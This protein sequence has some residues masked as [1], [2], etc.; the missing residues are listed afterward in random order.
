MG[1]SDARWDSHFGEMVMDSNTVASL[2][3]GDVRWI[4][5][6]NNAADDDVLLTDEQPL[7]SAA[8]D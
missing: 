7:P 4:R 2:Q 8:G 5:H 3:A 6:G 1:T